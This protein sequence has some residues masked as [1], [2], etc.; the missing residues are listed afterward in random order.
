MVS[1]SSKFRKFVLIFF[2]ETD[3]SIIT[4]ILYSVSLFREK[5]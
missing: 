2:Y 5:L 4:F 1:R 3:L